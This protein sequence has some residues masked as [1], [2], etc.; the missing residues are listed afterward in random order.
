MTPFYATN[1]QTRVMIRAAVRVISEYMGVTE[2]QAFALISERNV[3]VYHDRAQ[4]MFETIIGA[5]GT[6]IER[7]RK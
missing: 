6:L 7:M 5:N 2:P 4:R 3:T 1:E